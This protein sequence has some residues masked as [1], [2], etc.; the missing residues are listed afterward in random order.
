MTLVEYAPDTHSTFQRPSIQGR[1]MALGA[2]AAIGFALVTAVV[3]AMIDTPWF[4]REVPTTVWAWPSLVVASLLAG[5][6]V[7]VSMPGQNTN[8]GASRR[9][10]LGSVGMFLAVGCPVCNKIVLLALGSAGAMTWFAPIQP[11]LGAASIALLAWALWRQLRTPAVCSIP[12][13]RSTR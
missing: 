13:P 4:S 3:T 2:F 9:G 5:A 8:E 1:R 12:T 7:T 11:W 6:L 10:L